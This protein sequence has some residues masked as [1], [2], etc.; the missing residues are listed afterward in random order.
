MTRIIPVALALL[1]AGPAIASASTF[2]DRQARQADRIEHGRKTGEITWTEG[3]KLR[4][5][6][7][8]IAR[9]EVDLKS[10][11]YLSRSDKAKLAEKQNEASREIRNAADNNLHRAW[12]LPRV[13][14]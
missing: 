2:D 5:H 11:G 6:Q 4:K 10:D 8:E 13:G 12:F 7:R 1:I 9:L 3:L 14:K